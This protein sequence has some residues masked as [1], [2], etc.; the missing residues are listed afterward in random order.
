[1]KRGFFIS[2]LVIIMLSF[3]SY[4]TL[5]HPGRTDANGGHTCRTNCERWGLEYGEYHKHNNGNSSSSGSSSTS[6]NSGSSSNT[7][8]TN[9]Q[10]KP[11]YSQADVDEGKA[12]GESQGFEDGYNR[13]EKAANTSTGNEGYQKGYATG[14]EAGYQKGLQ[15]IKEED[16][17]DGTAIG[18][19]DGKAAFK[20]EE[21]SKASFDESK[22]ED[23]N[24]AYK[25]AFLTAY[26]HAEH[27]DSSRSAGYEL[28]YSLKDLVVPDKYKHDDELRKAFEQMYRAGYKKRTKE[29]NED[30]FDRGKE[31]GYALGSLETSEVDTK[32]Q[33][34]YIEGY[35]EGKSERKEEIISD[36][37]QSAF[38]HMDFK[39]STDYE[40][41]EAIQWYKEGYESNEIAKQ[42]KETAFEN[43]RNN[44]KYFIP[45]EIKVNEQSIKLY[46]KLF[47]EGQTVRSAE[48]KKKLLVAAGVS[49]GIGGTATGA[50]LI[51][52]KK[53]YSHRNT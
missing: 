3:S 33:E 19:K 31:V 23:W 25:D 40:D 13:N 35:E 9:S 44:S 43:G 29:E 14:Y 10:P 28:G 2:S 32:F 38:I 22:S 48:N 16:I 53:L 18:E 36:G 49:V 30:H 12:A 46:D 17:T 52:R 34:S 5:A 50:Y 7:G 6:A 21:E 26:A 39:Q 15:K 45:E 1:M 41:K 37:F 51:R 20:N 27:V 24:A 4:D 8:T 47:E 11:S 42:I